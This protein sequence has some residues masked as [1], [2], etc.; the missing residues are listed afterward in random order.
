MM[1][2]AYFDE[3]IDE[4]LNDNFPRTPSLFFFNNLVTG[5]Y[6]E[7]FRLIKNIL[8]AIRDSLSYII[9]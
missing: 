8:E 7:D 1:L 2:S 6:L 4:N 3:E 5:Y 9:S